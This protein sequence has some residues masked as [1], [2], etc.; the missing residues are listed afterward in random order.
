MGVMLNTGSKT[1][2][3]RINFTQKALND[4]FTLD[5]NLGATDRVAKYGFTDAFRYASVYNPTAPVRS[6]DPAYDIYDGYFQQILYD[7][8]NPV[9]IL[10]ANK[11]DGKDRLLLMAIKGTYQ[12]FKGF[13]IDAFYSRQNNNYLRGQY[14]DKNSYWGGRDRNGLA[15]EN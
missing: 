1:L 4:K 11:N 10:E 3:G 12:I 13:T 6:D 5:M 14:F 8:Y 7:Y 9:Q 15:K 2:N